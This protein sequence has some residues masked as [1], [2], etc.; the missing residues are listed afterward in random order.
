MP[1]RV[2]SDRARRRLSEREPSPAMR[3]LVELTPELDAAQAAYE[4][5]L[6]ERARL[7]TQTLDEDKLSQPEVA[8]LCEM[9]VDNVYRVV[10]A[11]REGRGPGRSGAA[12]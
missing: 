12:G 7:M 4:R 2:D 1:H 3:R 11:Y 8:L 6:G 9:S 5:L 10:R